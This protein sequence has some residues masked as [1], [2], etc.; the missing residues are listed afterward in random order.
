MRLRAAT[1]EVGSYSSLNHA[2]DSGRPK[3]NTL[4][5]PPHPPR[6]SN[7]S[8]PNSAALIYFFFAEV[9]PTACMLF[10]FRARGTNVPPLIASG[11]VASL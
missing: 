2:P 7:A 5:R 9:V 3:F 4:T 8:L 6:I 1:A 11:K 10:A